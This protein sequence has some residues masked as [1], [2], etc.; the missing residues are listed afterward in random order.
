L[1][2]VA[3][4]IAGIAVLRGLNS[5][6]TVDPEPSRDLAA[7]TP[8]PDHVPVGPEIV[9]PPVPALHTVESGDTLTDLAL[10]FGTTIQ[11]LQLVNDLENPNAIRI[12]QRL[13]V[14]P[15][16]SVQE[17]VERTQTLRDIARGRA[18]DPATLAAYNGLG[19]ERIDRPLGREAVLVPVRAGVPI[20]TAPA[21]ETPSRPTHV[22]QFG[23]TI[24]SIAEQ[25]EVDP[26][27]LIAA[28]A[29]GDPDLIVVGAELIIPHDD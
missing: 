1:F 25:W 12:G 13:A 23:E 24:A 11:A 20:V 14:P 18:L 19:P 17:P 5:G 16:Q 22:V 8:V 6:A 2:L 21:A 10:Q 4:L 29:L 15:A 7:D 9:L 3:A 28:N 26:A 27:A